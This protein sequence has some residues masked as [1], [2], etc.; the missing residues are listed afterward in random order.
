MKI[1]TWGTKGP[2]SL[3]VSTSVRSLTLGRLVL[4]SLV[5][6]SLVLLCLSFTLVRALS[7]DILPLFSP[8][9]C[10]ARSLMT[11][12]TTTDTLGRQRDL[13]K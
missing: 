13:A 5:L 4:F 7:V 8:A 11:W 10:V 12:V 6:F 1:D 2:G 9:T 3:E